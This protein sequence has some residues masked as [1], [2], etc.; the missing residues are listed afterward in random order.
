MSS[1]GLHSSTER[2]VGSLGLPQ[3]VFTPGY[4]RYHFARLEAAINRYE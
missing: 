1:R 2:L 4:L 3:T